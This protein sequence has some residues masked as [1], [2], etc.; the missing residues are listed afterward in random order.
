MTVSAAEVVAR[1]RADRRER[2]SAAARYAEAAQARMAVRAVVAFG[3]VAR[4]DWHA[5]SDIDVHGTARQRGGQATARRSK[6]R[7]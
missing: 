4:G 5:G 2:L 3:S 6:V 7:R 1:R